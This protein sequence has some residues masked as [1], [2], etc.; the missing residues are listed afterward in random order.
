VIKKS[1]LSQEHFYFSRTALRMEAIWSEDI[2]LWNK[3]LRR[4]TLRKTSSDYVEQPVASWIQ[5]YSR[6]KRPNNQ[7]I[8]KH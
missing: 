2:G 5:A 4:L 1:V 3:E 7:Y 8:T 6:K